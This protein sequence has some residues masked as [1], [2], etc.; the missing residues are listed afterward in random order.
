MCFVALLRLHDGRIIKSTLI[1]HSYLK[2]QLIRNI[3]IMRS[4]FL[5]FRYIIFSFS[6]FIISIDYQLLASS[7]GLPS[8]CVARRLIGFHCFIEGT[9]TFS[10]DNSVAIELKNGTGYPQRVCRNRDGA[11]VSARMES[12]SVAVCLFDRLWQPATRIGDTVGE[13]RFCAHIIITHTDRCSY[14]AATLEYLN[15]YKN[16]ATLLQ[17]CWNVLR[18]TGPRL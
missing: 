6:S 17:Y 18:Y 11:A 5:I 14:I 1:K 12:L 10:R 13:E 16:I 15:Y 8:L 3:L 4:V 9:M 7:H 2:W